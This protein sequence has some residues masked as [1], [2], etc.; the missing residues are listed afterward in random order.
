MSFGRRRIEN[1][2]LDFGNALNVKSE[3]YSSNSS[4]RTSE[5]LSSG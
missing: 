3:I 2:N 1:I 4:E 5:W